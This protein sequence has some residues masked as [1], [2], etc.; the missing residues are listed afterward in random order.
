M[1]YRLDVVAVGR[2]ENF[3][4]GKLFG[5][6]SEEELL[7]YK[8]LSDNN[9]IDE[10]TCFDYGCSGNILLESH[11]LKEFLSLY[12]KDLE[13]NDFGYSN[14]RLIEDII[15]YIKTL[16]HDEYPHLYVLIWG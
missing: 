11:E 7:S 16:E 2:D 8:W 12:V 14:K 13:S 3:C 4:C 15:E 9:Y 6:V 5:Y 1:G 10:Y